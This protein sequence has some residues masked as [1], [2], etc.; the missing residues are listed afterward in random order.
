M[1]VQEGTPGVQRQAWLLEAGEAELRR[2]LA[3]DSSGS[4]GSLGIPLTTP[5][6]SQISHIACIPDQPCQRM[7]CRPGVRGPCDPP[8][9][10][11]EPS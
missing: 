9:P 7:G 8:L 10:P 3:Q 4:S 2:A 5:T 6:R 1:C 11:P